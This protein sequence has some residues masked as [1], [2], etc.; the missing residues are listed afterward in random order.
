MIKGVEILIYCEDT[1]DALPLLAAVHANLRLDTNGRMDVQTIQRS[2]DIDDKLV[3][4]EV[5]V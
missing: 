4:A 5:Y 2:D 1:D 3:L